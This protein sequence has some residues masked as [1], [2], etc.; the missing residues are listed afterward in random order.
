MKLRS[1]A[2]SFVCCIDVADDSH[3][4]MLPLAALVFK[5]MV[6]VVVTAAL[7]MIR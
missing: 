4:L 5:E 6:A 2:L 7:Q 1:I 3:S